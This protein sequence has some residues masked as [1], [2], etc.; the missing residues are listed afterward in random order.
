MS[1]S[2]GTAW[3]EFDFSISYAG[4]DR[5]IARE[6]AEKLAGSGWRVFYDRFYPGRLLGARLDREFRWVFGEGTRFFVPL[7]SRHYAE[8]DWPQLEWRIG[9]EEAKRRDQHFLLP[10]RLDDTPLLGLR[11]T[12]GYIDLREHSVDGVAEALSDKRRAE[13][14]VK[15]AYLAPQ[16]WVATFGLVVEDLMQAGVLPDAAPEDYPSLCDW[17]E[18][19]LIRRLQRAPI[20]NPRFPEAS[21]RNG[22]TLSVRVA[23]E[24]VPRRDALTFGELP[25]WEVLEVLPWGE[26]YDVEARAIQ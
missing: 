10:V 11:D 7:V 17:L 14:M 4:A 6:L 5:A 9:R 18:D 21:A 8:G 22:E 19:D 13:V 2:G 24:W 25:W 23:F 3:Y 12:V 15:G 20:S 16:T 26:V 1:A